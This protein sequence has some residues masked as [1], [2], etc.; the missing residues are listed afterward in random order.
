MSISWVNNNK[1]VVIENGN[2]NVRYKLS[3]GSPI[4]SIKKYKQLNGRYKYNVERVGD[5]S[6]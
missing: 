3:S 4:I 1:Y 6:Y 2:S 5:G